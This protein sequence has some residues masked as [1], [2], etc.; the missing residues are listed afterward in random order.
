MKLLF[1]KISA[2]KYYKGASQKDVPYNG[3]SYVNENGFGNEQYNFAAVQLDD[4]RD[5]CL[6]FVETKTTSKTKRN[7]LHIEKIDGCEL[8]KKEDSVDGVL[9][10]WCATTDLN[11]TSIIGW[12]QDATVYRFYQNAEFDSGYNQE[13]NVLANKENCVLLPQGER[14]RHIWDAPVAK[15]RTYGFGQSM[16]W[17]ATE[18]NA[19]AYIEKL[20]KQ[21]SEYTGENWIDKS[22]EDTNG[23][24]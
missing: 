1:C 14:H 13:F 20:A 11:E 22:A 12:Y 24:A 21:I 8:I 19:T 2:M 15:K 3:G 6:G 23:H 18:E 4:G 17:Y 7:E 10:V 9:V 16:I 5:Y